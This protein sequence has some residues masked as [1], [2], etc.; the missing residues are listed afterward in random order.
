MRLINNRLRTSLRYVLNLGKQYWDANCNISDAFALL[1]DT[2]VCSLLTGKPIRLLSLDIS[3][4]FYRITHADL[5]SMLLT[6]GCNL[7]LIGLINFVYEKATAKIQ[8]HGHYWWPNPIIFSIQQC[9]LLSTI[10]FSPTVFCIGLRDI[11]KNSDQAGP[12]TD[13]SDR[14]RGPCGVPLEG[15]FWNRCCGNTDTLYAGSWLA[16]LYSKID[17][18]T[19]RTI[20]DNENYNGSPILVGEEVTCVRF[21]ASV[22]DIVSILWNVVTQSTKCPVLQKYYWTS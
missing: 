4:A 22:V 3:S 1:R 20:G 8:I 2:I 6:H 10:L 17:C 11:Y 9:S 7:Q 15:P 13:G 16:A 18:S 5:L 12:N 19:G 14:V 21:S